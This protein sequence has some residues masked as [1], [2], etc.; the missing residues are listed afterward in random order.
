MIHLNYSLTKKQYK[1]FFMQAM[2]VYSMKIYVVVLAV[3]TA[4]S[5]IIGLIMKNDA[6]QN[7][8]LTMLT[9]YIPTLIL[10]ALFS[11]F[12]SWKDLRKIEKLHP[13]ILEGDFKIRFEKNF[14]IWQVDGQNKK[15]TYDPYRLYKGFNNSF[16]LQ[17]LHEKK[18]IVIP[19]NALT[20]EQIKTIK[21]NIRG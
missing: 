18:H 13:E 8:G 7:F 17:H 5:T 3:G 20:K 12:V 10:C 21:Q 1:K 19:E 4:I 16:V 6:M 2:I 9:T 11:L 15:L 14:I